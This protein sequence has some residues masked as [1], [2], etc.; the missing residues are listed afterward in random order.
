[1]KERDCVFCEIVAGRS[2]ATIRYED[3]QVIVID[4]RLRWL[5]V[6]LLV[7]PRRHITQEDMWRDNGVM[8]RVAQVAVEVGSRLCP[9]GFRLLSNFGPDA[10]QTQEHGHLHILGG[11][12]L[13]HY[14]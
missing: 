13:G 4:N 10:L 7:I 12:P 3:D 6:M 9:G 14:A 11:M 2:P 5:P 1:M 8:G